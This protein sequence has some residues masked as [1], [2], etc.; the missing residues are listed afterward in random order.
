MEG[1]DFVVV[2]SNHDVEMLQSGP[3]PYPLKRRI[4]SAKGHLSNETCAD[5][6]PH[7][8]GKGTTRFLL[9]HLSQENNTPELAYQTALCSLQM[10]GLHLDRDFSLS[11]APRENTA[12]QTILF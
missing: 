5:L 2:E 10:A 11:V 7:L 1:A 8:A 3:Y 9:A 6:L 12:G 4:L